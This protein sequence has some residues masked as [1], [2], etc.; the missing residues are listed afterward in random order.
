VADHKTA[1]LPNPQGVTRKTTPSRV[2]IQAYLAQ[3]R[4]ATA[5]DL[6]SA[7]G[8]GR[9]AVRKHL[10]VLVESAFVEAMEPSTSRNQQY[11]WLK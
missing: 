11:R 10:V 7:T 2:L 1:D 4:L 9:S 6:E 5:A 3:H 8:L